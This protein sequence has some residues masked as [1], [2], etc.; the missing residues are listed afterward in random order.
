IRAVTVHTGYVNPTPIPS[1]DPGALCLEFVYAGPLADVTAATS[2]S[3]HSPA[4][5]AA[6]VGARHDRVETSVAG[7]SASATATATERELVDAIGLRDAIASVALDFEAGREPAPDAV[8][9]V[10]LYAATPD[11]PPVLA[12]GRRQAGRSSVRV[13]QVLSTVARRS[14]ERRVGKE[15]RPGVA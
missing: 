7:A 3:W 14:E 5:F 12:G 10:N 9:T 4:D 13:S 2:E 1:F 6:W 15:C 8:D 11:I